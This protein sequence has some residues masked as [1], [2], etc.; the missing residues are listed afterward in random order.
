MFEAFFNFRHTPFERGLPPDSLYTT[1]AL[2]ELMSRLE[3]A[4]T[5]RKFS[6][7]TGDTGVGKTTAVRKFVAS[8]AG[9]NCR[10]VYIADSALRPRVFYWKVLSQIADDEKPSF[11]RNEGK[12]KM[13]AHMTRLPEEE[14]PN[15]FINDRLILINNTFHF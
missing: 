1:P 5:R 13:M 14:K 7:I 3:Y 4:A 6:V 10:C 11:Y 12:R 15:D 9:V 8:L 2:K